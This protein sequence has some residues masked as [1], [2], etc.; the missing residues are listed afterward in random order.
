MSQNLSSA[1]VV[2]GALRVKKVFQYLWRH[3][4]KLKDIIIGLITVLVNIKGH[5][6]MS[7]QLLFNAIADNLCKQFGSNQA[8]PNVGP[9]LDPNCLTVL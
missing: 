7:R 4:Q 3:S 9:D 1:A 5:V 8:R 6:L 2:I